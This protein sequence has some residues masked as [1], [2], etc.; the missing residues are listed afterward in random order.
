MKS[1][2]FVI[3]DLYDCIDVL[4]LY[5]CLIY[6]SMSDKNCT[7]VLHLSLVLQ[8]RFGEARL[9]WTS[10]LANY[11]LCCGFQLVLCCV[12]SPYLIR[13]CPTFL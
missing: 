6:V 7:R 10:P 4:Y 8:V 11:I 13:G 12:L 5:Q 2:K 3:I 9:P 1:T